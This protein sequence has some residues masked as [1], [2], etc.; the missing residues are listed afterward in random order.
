M[1]NWWLTRLLCVCALA[2][3]V[4]SL[5]CNAFSADRQRRRAISIRTDLDHM[6]DDFDWILG[7][8]EPST[9][10]EQSFPPYKY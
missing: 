5:G 2:G 6:V 8:D 4:V 9:L 1:R 7:L 10:H 3:L